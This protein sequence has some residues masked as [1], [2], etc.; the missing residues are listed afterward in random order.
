MYR[1]FLIF[2][3][4]IAMTA[5]SGGPTVRKEAATAESNFEEG[6][7]LKQEKE[8][9]L[10]IEKFEI[11]KHRFPFSS[12]AKKAELE[13]ADIHFIRKAYPEARTTYEVYLQFHPIGKE[14][15][16]VMYRI[17]LTYFYEMPGSIDR[18]LEPIQQTVD[19]FE[20][21]LTQYPNSEYA[22][23]ARQKSLVALGKLAK[24][25]LYIARFYYKREDFEA[26]IS[27]ATEILQKYPTT[28]NNEEAYFYI[29]SS[30]DKLNSKGQAKEFYKKLVREFPN[31]K[32][33][34][35]FKQYGN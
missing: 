5:C 13:I 25:S 22:A 10:A 21:F 18:D 30:Y 24:R 26:A 12:Q 27:R 23:D 29:I 35:E 33:V 16:L 17:G 9:E 6:L 8:Y 19:A 20:K 14:I 11:V 1:F 4:V 2:L 3:L 7:K 15:P 34:N 31:S 32:Y 28:G